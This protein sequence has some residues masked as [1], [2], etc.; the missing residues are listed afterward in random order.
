LRGDLEHGRVH[1]LQRIDALLE[2][3]VVR[4]KL[5]LSYSLS[6]PIQTFVAVEPEG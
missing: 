6:V 3:D 2:L 1:L 4:R 5:G